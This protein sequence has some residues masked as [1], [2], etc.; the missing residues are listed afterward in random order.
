MAVM[1][2]CG[3]LLGTRELNERETVPMPSLDVIKCPGPLAKHTCQSLRRGTAPRN[4]RVLFLLKAAAEW[5]CF[6][7]GLLALCPSMESLLTPWSTCTP[8]RKNS[9]SLFT[10]ASGL[11]TEP[12]YAMTT[13]TG[14]SVH[15]K[16][17]NEVPDRVSLANPSAFHCPPPFLLF[18]L[19]NLW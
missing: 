13:A 1:T 8:L 4:G 19:L 5:A 16:L 2:R 15:F 18:L 14:T 12:S 17:D 3:S 10:Q 9:R 6:W 11:H 7:T